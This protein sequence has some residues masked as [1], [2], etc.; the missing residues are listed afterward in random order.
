M[1]S[2]ATIALWR[3]TS[4]VA[5]PHPRT[6]GTHIVLLTEQKRK[7][8]ELLFAGGLYG[9]PETLGRP[10]SGLHVSFHL[11]GDAWTGPIALGNSLGL[12]AGFDASLSPDGRF[13]FLLDRGTRVYWVDVDVL[14]L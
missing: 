13:L 8:S 12:E 14:E 6:L 11:P 10:D 7:I 3:V 5:E 2:S 9:T 1:Y 4:L